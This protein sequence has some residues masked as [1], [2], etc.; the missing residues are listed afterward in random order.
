MRR[1]STTTRDELLAAT[2]ER[3]RSSGREAKSRTLDEFASVTGLHRKRAMRLLRDGPGPARPRPRP[4]RRLYD[5]AVLEALILLWEASDRVCSKRLRPLLPVL[6]TAVERHGHLELD[7]V[8]R[9]RL[10]RISAATIDRAPASVREQV[11]GRRR[12]HAA[13][14]A[15]LRRSV[16]IRTLS[17]CDDPAP[18]HVEADLVAQ[19]GPVASGAFV[20]TLVLTDVATG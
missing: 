1:V 12:R 18:G 4:A 15:A 11:G 10:P 2:A 14:R 6:V 3:Y 5:E 16:P 9:E 8:V 7:A 17:C 20:Q 13:P 19:S